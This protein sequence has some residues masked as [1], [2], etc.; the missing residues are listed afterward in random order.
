MRAD[1]LVAAATGAYA[2]NVA[3]G[4]ATAT[5]VVD[6]SRFRWVHHALYI[7]TASLTVVAVATN[8]RSVPGRRLVPALVPLAVIPYA[9][10]HSRRH[11]AVAAAAA[12]FYALAA[13]ARS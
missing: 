4:V 3:L 11:Y 13:L 5:R 1:A 6:T 12:P 7:V 10:T 8:V 9:G 2:A